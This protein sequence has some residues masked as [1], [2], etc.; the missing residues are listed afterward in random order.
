MTSALVLALLV[1]GVFCKDERNGESARTTAK[2]SDDAD[3]Q[4]RRERLTWPPK[5]PSDLGPPSVGV[6]LFREARVWKTLKGR[7]TLDRDM[8]LLFAACDRPQDAAKHSGLTLEEIGRLEAV[9]RK[10]W[11]DGVGFVFPPQ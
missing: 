10:R 6:R 11:R 8:T 5:S 2:R 9:M 7:D 1:S 3:P 4:A